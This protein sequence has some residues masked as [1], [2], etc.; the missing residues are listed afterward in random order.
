TLG[1]ETRT[2]VGSDMLGEVLRFAK[3]ENV[4]Q[5]VIGRSRGGLFA[6]IFRRSLPHELMRRTEDIAVH[7]V[8]GRAEGIQPMRR[9]RLMIEPVQDL[10]PYVWSTLAVAA[11]IGI[12]EVISTLTPLPNLSM[13][14]LMAVLFAAVTFGIWPAIYASI[15]SFLAY[16]FFFIEPIY[17]F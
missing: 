10:M 15:L 13:V 4:T 9:L 11:A 17:T 14:F 7:L 2:L 3:F 16:N 12:G 5:I 6:E 1:A 8:T